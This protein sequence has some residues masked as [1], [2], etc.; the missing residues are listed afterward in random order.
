MQND[1]KLYTESKFASNTS[2]GNKTPNATFTKNANKGTS[3]KPSEV[4]NMIKII[5]KKEGK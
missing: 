2:V 5:N 3:P 4:N 1:Q